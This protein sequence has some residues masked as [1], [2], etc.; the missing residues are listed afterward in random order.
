MRARA[1]GRGWCPGHDRWPFSGPN[2]PILMVSPRGSEH[3]ENSAREGA[4]G[5][6]P[7][8]SGTAEGY[9]PAG[10]GCPD[11]PGCTAETGCLPSPKPALGPWPVFGVQ[12]LR[13]VCPRAASW[14]AGGGSSRLRRPPTHSREG[15]AG[16]CNRVSLCPAPGATLS[17]SLSDESSLLPEIHRI[18]RGPVEEVRRSVNHLEACLAQNVCIISVCKCGLGLRPSLRMSSVCIG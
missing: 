6:Q 11:A 15:P 9:Q 7:G 12:E 1:P 18:L 3:P 14:Q 17:H 13:T 10:G 16:K 4:R 2:V 5:P 8:L